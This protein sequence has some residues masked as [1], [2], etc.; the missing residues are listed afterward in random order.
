MKICPEGTF[1]LNCTNNCTCE[2]GAICSPIDGSCTCSPGWMGE[3]CNKRVCQDEL[4][5]SNCTKV[6]NNIINV[7]FMFLYYF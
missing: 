6:C 5:G 4:W 3:K 1:G 2:N 7:I